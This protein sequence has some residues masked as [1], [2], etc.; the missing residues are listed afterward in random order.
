MKYNYIYW[1]RHQQFIQD[2]NWCTRVLII[3]RRFYLAWFY[4][5]NQQ[6]MKIYK[7]QIKCMKDWMQYN[8]WYKKHHKLIDLNF[9]KIDAYNICI[10]WNWFPVNYKTFLP[11]LVAM[12]LILIFVL[13]TARTFQNWYFHFLTCKNNINMLLKLREQEIES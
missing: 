6:K 3:F 10:I 8:G 5:F 13:L 2:K 4:N 12:W 7:M 1:T 9:L 11:E